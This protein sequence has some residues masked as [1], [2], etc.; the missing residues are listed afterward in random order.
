MEV[1]MI[2]TGSAFSRG[3]GNTSALVK[4]DSGYNLLIDC[5]H[6][7]PARLDQQKI[8]LSDID[9][10]L[11]THLHADHIGGLEE[12]AFKNMYMHNG[13]KM[14]LLVPESIVTEL[15]EHSLRGG[16]EQLGE[17]ITALSDY[18][19]VHPLDE[20][21]SDA[22]PTGAHIFIYQTEHVRGM[23][24]YAVSI[25]SFLY[26]GDTLFNPAWLDN[27]SGHEVIFHDCQLFKGGIH[28]SLEELLT[29][30]E[31]MQRKIYLMHYGDQVDSFTG[32]TGKM[33]FAV[34]GVDYVI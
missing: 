20:R 29:L 17:G 13:R 21:G 22:H 31:E 19:H 12:V 26:T 3:Y 4:L 15:W 7:V 34:P 6:N 11:I 30:P 28:A 24:S 16:L 5:G 9:G 33:R 23:D 14:D 18:F 25:G 1:R 32:T 27:L 8:D 2:G 10:I